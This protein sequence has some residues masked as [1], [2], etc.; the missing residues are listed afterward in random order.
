MG[1]PLFGVNISGLIHQAMSGGL[2]P[3]TLTR[4]TISSRDSADLSAGVRP[5]GTEHSARGFV[6]TYKDGRIDGT[7]IQKGDRIVTLIGD[8]IQPLAVPQINDLVTIEGK[9]YTILDVKRDPAAATYEM[10]AR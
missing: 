1:I 5:T 6:D 9:Q 2:L 8:S 4:L 3:A 10:Q 7:I